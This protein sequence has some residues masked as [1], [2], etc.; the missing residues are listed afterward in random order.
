MSDFF[1]N[2]SARY[3]IGIQLVLFLIGFCSCS[4]FQRD[5]KLFTLLPSDKT[6]I[7]FS[8]QLK[9]GLDFNIIEYLYYYD[10]GGVAVG[11]INNDGLPDLY[12]T[13]NELPDKLYLN[14]GNFV[15]EDIS[16]SAGIENTDGWSTGV[17]MVDIN[18]D[19]YLDIYVCQL[20]GYKGKTGMNKLFVNNGGSSKGL[21]GVTFTE[22]ARDYGINFVGFSTQASFFDYDNDGDLDVYLLNHAIHSSRSYGS[23]SLRLEKDFKAGD[24][25]FRNDSE[26]RS[27]RFLDVTDESG[28]YSSHIGYGLGIT[29]GDLN[30]DGC[31]DIFISNDFHENDYLY[32][33]NC[34]GTFTD[35]LEQFMGHTSRSSMGNDIA[36]FNNDGLLDIV[37]LD[38]LPENE[39]ILKRSAGE[40]PLEIYETKLSFGYYH[41]LVRNTLQ[42]NRG[43]GKFSDIA[44]LSGI[45]ATDW[46]WSPLFCDL[47]N[48]G[49]KDLFITN[50]IPNRPN[51]LDYYTYL[52]SLGSKVD[53]ISDR[54][55]IN[56]ILVDSMPSEKISNYAYRNN[57]D[58]TFSNST[59]EWG[60][61]E[62]GY[63]NGAAYADLDNDGDLDLI[64]NN[65]NGEASL[66]QNNLKAAK[67]NNYLKISLKGSAQ[68][69]FGIGTKIILKINTSTFYKEQ[70]PVRGFQS[71]VD[72]VLH[73]GLGGFETMDT[74]Q[75]VWPDG[76]SQILTGVKA[77]QLLILDQNDAGIQYRYASA[78]NPNTMFTDI[79]ETIKIDYKHRENDPAESQESLKPHSLDTQGPCLAVGDINGDNL[80][81]IFIGGATHQKSAIFIQ[82]KDGK[83]TI[84]SQPVIENDSIAEDVDALFLDVDN[85]SDLDL[86]VVSGGSEWG[87]LDERYKDRI[88]I[89]N[90]TGSFSKSSNSLPKGF[91]ANGSCVVAADFDGDNDADLFIGSRSQFSQYGLSPRSYILENSGTGIYTDVTLKLAPELMDLGMIT[92]AVW[93]DIDGNGSLDLVVVGDWIPITVLENIGGTFE[94]VTENVGLGRTNGMWNTIVVDD[95]DGD[96]DVDFIAGNLGLNSKMKASGSEPATIY[97]GDF[98]NSGNLDHILTFYKNGENTIFATRDELLKQMGGLKTKFPT[99]TTYSKASSVL[100]LFSSDQLETAVKK[101][102]YMLESSYIENHQ[103]DSFSIRP[104]PIYAQFSPIHSLLT[105]DFNQDGNPDLL[106]GGNFNSAAINFGLYDA[107]Y[108]EIFEGD[109]NGGFTALDHSESGLMV[110]GEIRDIKKAVLADGTII[111]LIARNNDTLKIFKWNDIHGAHNKAD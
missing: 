31:I 15:F 58:L 41:Q 110:R 89:N 75:V 3:S 56:K 14:K 78:R 7:R 6:N 93:A 69:I 72:Y 27:F 8:N 4:W 108:G 101:E 21:P 65:L 49:N 1:R 20:G 5:K 54:N 11:D 50:G 74:L 18:A 61:D 80:D 103:G 57:G 37:V 98:D 82:T 62:P 9:E 59:K 43:N 97:I 51:D 77:N 36:D 60:L 106:L 47:D 95:F 44:L 85:D 16:Q 84:S 64:L 76:R 40:D 87:A 12:F 30:N 29:I 88:Y 107:S 24:K 48:D 23:S 38:M 17:T 22:R 35:K 91:I 71:S 102:V 66:Y 90:G 92:G 28:I 46:S 81:D 34:D 26:G 42:L 19:G 63:S 104:L 70:M 100:D 33:N 94:N 96:G 83:F 73:F 10:G 39:E 86:Y 55:F 2:F 79:S 45:Y 67:G 52:T 109:G 99:Y 105:E 68:N 53:Q 111:I 25:L 13:A 32:I